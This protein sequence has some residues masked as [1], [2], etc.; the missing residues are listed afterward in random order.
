[1]TTLCILSLD[2]QDL[3]SDAR[4]LRQIEYL[5]ENHS[6]HFL[7]CGDENIKLNTKAESVAYFG[8]L[9]KNRGKRIVLT[10]ILLFLGRLFGSYFYKIWYWWRPGHKE[11]L[12]SI[13]KIK[14]DAIHAN[15]WWSVPVAVQAKKEIGSKVIADFHEYSPDQFSSF[16]W[17]IFYKPV[18]NSFIRI[19]LP[20]IDASV[21]VNNIM[22]ARYKL[23]F[24]LDPIV[25]MNA[26]KLGVLPV[27]KKE[28][29]GIHMVHYGIALRARNIERM[30]DVIP[31]CDSRFSLSFYFLGDER[32]IK[33]LKAYAQRIAPDRIK[34][35]PGVFPHELT[36]TLSTYDIGLHILRDNHYNHY[37]SLPNKF[38]EFVS[39]GLA[40][41]IGPSPAMSELVY[42]YGFGIVGDDFTPA[43]I[44]KRLNML[45]SEDISIMKSK[46]IEARRYLN[47]D[48][49]MDKLKKL[50][51]FLL[52]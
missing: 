52:E 39:A 28:L 50:Y 3:H 41:C 43:T 30:M 11:A 33:T 37:A 12:A 49:E 15:D 20:Y 47:A 31:L 32:Y 6:V 29:D 46:A 34:I 9:S 45:S 14:P 10:M 27:D 36:E 2:S 4:V 7:G 1:M 22:A 44:A 51:S 25:V 17:R 23:E 16:F 24:N 42:K 18:V 8:Q 5:A 13:I 40:V 35:F 19:S 48:I 26:P 38:F 21:T